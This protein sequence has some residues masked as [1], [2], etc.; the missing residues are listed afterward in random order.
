V[1]FVQGGMENAWIRTLAA[2][3][4][5]SWIHPSTFFPVDLNGPLWYISYDVMGGLTVIAVMTVLTRLP[6]KAA[7]W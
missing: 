2:F 6:K 4:F 5:L 3:T 1:F 7:W